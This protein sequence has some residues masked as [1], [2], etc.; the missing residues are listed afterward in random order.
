MA[1]QQQS[2]GQQGNWQG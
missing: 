1:R 2:D